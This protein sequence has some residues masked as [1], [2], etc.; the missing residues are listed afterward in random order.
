LSVVAWQNF[1]VAL[2][3]ETPNIFFGVPF[4]KAAARFC[5]ATTLNKEMLP[6]Q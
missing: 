4:A 2:A 1:A 3:K 5:Q 6:V